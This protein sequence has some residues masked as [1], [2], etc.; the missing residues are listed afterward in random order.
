MTEYVQRSYARHRALDLLLKLEDEEE[1]RFG[2]ELG[3]F[4]SQF[5]D[6]GDAFPRRPRL[7]MT[8]ELPGPASIHT[9]GFALEP[10][11]AHVSSVF[12]HEAERVLLAAETK[13]GGGTRRLVGPAIHVRG[14]PTDLPPDSAEWHRLSCPITVDWDWS[15]FRVSVPPKS[16]SWGDTFS[17]SLLETWVQPGPREKQTPELA[18]VAPSGTVHR[19]R[20]RPV[21]G[22]RYL[23]EFRPTELGLWRYG[24]SFRP[25]PTRPLGG[26][27]GEGVFYVMPAYG[28]DGLERLTEFAGRLVRWARHTRPDSPALQTNV[29]GFVRWA[30][31]IGD[32]DAERATAVDSLI[33]EVRAAVES[34]R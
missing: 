8:V 27:E 12:E 32:S 26:H 17:V 34:S 19:V 11:M 6:D 30:V 16:V 33:A 31:A 24:W 2:T 5:G 25:T 21:A 4:S 22:L 1:D 9:E 18:L 7:D 3:I 15:Q 20:G 28:D 14:G 10:G 23:M 29:A 13:G